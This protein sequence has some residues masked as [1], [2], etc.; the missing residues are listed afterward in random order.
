MCMAMRGIR[1]QGSTTLT[2]TFT[3][4]VQGQPGEQIRFVTMVRRRATAVA[5]DHA[6]VPPFRYIT[7]S[8]PMT[9]HA[10]C[11]PVS[12]KGPSK[13]R[14][15]LAALRRDG[16]ITA[17]VTDA[18]RRRAADGGAHE[19]GGA[20]ADAR[21]RHRPL[22]VALAQERSGRRAKHRATCSRSSRCAPIA[23]RTR[24]GCASK[25]PATTQPVTPAGVHAS[26]GR[27]VA[28]GWQ[29]YGLDDRRLVASPFR[30][31]LRK[32]IVLNRLPNSQTTHLHPF[33]TAPRYQCVRDKRRW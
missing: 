2:S 14:G 21:D 19:R 15:V 13:R 16:L 1:K 22:L 4:V 30:S 23:T 6:A 31:T 18:A 3:G 26:T 24:C 7:R 9:S 25:C 10:I 28:G 33:D 17:V 8:R 5:I 27:S 20:G 32:R 12:D 29:R 11:P